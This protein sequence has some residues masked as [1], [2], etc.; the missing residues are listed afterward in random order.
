[1]TWREAQ[2]YCRTN[3][4]DLI[5]GVQQLEDFK[6]DPGYMLLYTQEPD[7]NSGSACSGTFTG[8]G[9]MGALLFH[10]WDEENPDPDRDPKKTC[11]MTTSG[12]AWS[13]DDYSLFLIKENRTW[14]DA[15][16]YCRDLY[17]DLVSIANL[18][19]QLWVQERAKMATTYYV[20]LGLRY[21][22]T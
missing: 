1:M 13:S 12:G 7:E 22:C 6:T 20:W 10:N 8:A 16:Y 15:L 14:E 2:N 21:T 4:T 5:S 17:G 9:L 18:D 19:Q 11:A 3:H